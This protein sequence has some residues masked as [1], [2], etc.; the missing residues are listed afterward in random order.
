MDEEE[1]PAEEVPEE[2][3]VRVIDPSK[4]MVALTFDDGPH[5]TYT[6]AF[7]TK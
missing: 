5:K 6:D 1:I 2:P 3:Y 7:L 4:P